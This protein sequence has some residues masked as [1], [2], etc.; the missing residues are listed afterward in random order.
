M[1]D[2]TD[3]ERERIAKKLA[4]QRAKL[5]GM[6]T[7]AKVIVLSGMILY[8]Y[9]QRWNIRNI[10]SYNTYI[11]FLQLKIDEFESNVN[12]VKDPFPPADFPGNRKP[13]NF[14]FFLI[15]DLWTH[16]LVM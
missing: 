5:E 8:L 7:T 1:P 11:S 6:P 2:K 16:F 14:Y 13:L 9:S 10:S 3:E 15:S 4:E 12:E